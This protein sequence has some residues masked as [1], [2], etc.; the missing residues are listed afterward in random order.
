[1][2]DKPDELIPRLF[3]LTA[4]DVRMIGELRAF[5]DAP[6]DATIVRAAIRQMHFRTYDA[7]PPK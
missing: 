7:N 6:F 1:M 2:T 5:H 4:D 3:R